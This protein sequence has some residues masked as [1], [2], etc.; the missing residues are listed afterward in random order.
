M[1]IYINDD[2]GPD[3]RKS[4][5][6]SLDDATKG[7][8]GLA[9]RDLRLPHGAIP[10]DSTIIVTICHSGSYRRP[11]TSSDGGRRRGRLVS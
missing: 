6:P 1:G 8:L 7:V 10:Q 5:L 9:L 3:M 11:D 2:P 4:R